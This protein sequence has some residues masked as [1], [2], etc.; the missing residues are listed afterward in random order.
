MHDKQI[1]ILMVDKNLAD[2]HVVRDMLAKVDGRMFSM[3]CAETLVAALDLMAQHEFDVALVDLSLSDSDGLETFETIRRHAQTLPIVVY[4]TFQNE[5]LALTAVER[6]AQDYLIKGRMTPA[7]L[8]RVLQFSVAR[9]RNSAHSPLEP[10]KRATMIGVMGAKGGV[11][12]TTLACHLSIE[13]GKQSGE[14]VL[15]VDLDAAA[16]SSAFLMQIKSDYSVVEATTNLHRL[17]SDYWRGIVCE[18]PHGVDV[19]QSPGAVGSSEPLSGERVRHVLRFTQALYGSIV[20]DL[21]RLGPL[22]MSLLEGLTQLHVVSSG[23]IPELYEAGRLLRKL[24]ELGHSEKLRLVVN[25]ASKIG[26]GSSLE[27]ALG[28]PAFWTFPDCSKELAETYADGQFVNGGTPL[29]KRWRKW[30]LRPSA[31]TTSRPPGIC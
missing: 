3:R 15:L 21:G 22:S 1:S 19:L 5:A 12:C 4:A 28:Y 27:K 29:Q 23:E 11:G 20:I 31:A 14:K 10:A 2:T 9:Q 26:F 25:R 6:G 13:L 17:D 24:T 18:S 16:A 30:S 7:A 8:V